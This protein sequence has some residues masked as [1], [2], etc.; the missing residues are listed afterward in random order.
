[1]HRTYEFYKVTCPNKLIIIEPLLVEMVVAMGLQWV[2]G[3]ETWVNIIA[4]WR[5]AGPD[6]SGLLNLIQT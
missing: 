6:N 1:M 5:G 2:G 4:T 3:R